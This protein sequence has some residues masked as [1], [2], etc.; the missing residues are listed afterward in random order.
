MKKGWKTLIL[1]LVGIASS[2]TIFSTVKGYVDQKKTD[3][4][5]NAESGSAYVRLMEVA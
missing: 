1:I 3:T 2:I 4:T 5:T